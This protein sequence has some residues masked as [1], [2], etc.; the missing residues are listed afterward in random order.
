M[1]I[2]KENSK[3]F[4]SYLVN[5]F[6]VYFQFV[7]FRTFFTRNESNMNLCQAALAKEV[8]AEVPDQFLSYMKAHSISPKPRPTISAPAPQL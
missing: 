6:C 8:L 1:M 4:D 5:L 2:I 3:R 7:P